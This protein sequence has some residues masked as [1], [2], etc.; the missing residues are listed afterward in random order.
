MLTPAGPLGSGREGLPVPRRGCASRDGF[1]T[2]G[3]KYSLSMMY[4]CW[5]QKVSYQKC[6]E[7]GV[8]NNCDLKVSI[9]KQEW[10]LGARCSI[11]SKPFNVAARSYCPEKKWCSQCQECSPAGAEHLGWTSSPQVSMALGGH[12]GNRLL[13]ALV[14]V[15]VPA[16][17]LKWWICFNLLL[18][19]LSSYDPSGVLSIILFK[20]MSKSFTLR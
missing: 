13:C 8:Q 7:F 11:K 15:W 17:G 4:P 5:I 18:I 12:T 16:E 3:L 1:C 19:V 20:K 9:S 14:S 6:Q 10:D 2:A